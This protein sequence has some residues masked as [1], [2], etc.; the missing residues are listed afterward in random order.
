MGHIN[1]YRDRQYF[2]HELSGNEVSEGIR[3]IGNNISNQIN[4]ANSI[5][6][7]ANESTLANNQID[8]STK[9]LAKNNEINTKWQA[10]PTNPQR[11]K[12]I[13]EAFETLSS[14]YKV[15]PLCE[16]QWS[17]IKSNVFN[18]YKTYNAQWAEKQ[19]QTNI[20]TNL[21]NGYE[22]LTNQ[23]SMLGLNG[24]GVDEVRLIY[25]NGIEGLKN[26][27]IAGLGEVYVNEFLKDSNHDI[28][29]TYIS[30]LALNKP[31]E[32]QK[33]LNDEG[34][35]NDI[36]NAETLE[37]LDNYVSNSLNNQSKKTA[38]CELG[39]ALRSMNSKD[40]D[41]IING[42][43]DLNKVMKFVETNKNLPEGSKDL[44]LNIYGI[45]SKSEYFYDKDK[46]KIVKQEE[47][48][49]R[50]HSGRSGNSLVAL[51][52][53]SKMEKQDLAIKLEEGL[54]ELFSFGEIKPV[55][56]KNEI[57]NNTGKNTQNNVLARLQSVAEAQGAIDTAYNA[58]IITKAQRQNM[59]NKFI[60]PM[61][62]FLD[63]NMQNL[64]EKQ[65][66]F[67]AKLG[68]DRL[69]K[70]FSVDD[71][72]ERNKN[73]IRAVKKSLL[74]A[75]GSYY[76]S[77]EAAR[78]KY[79]LQSIYDLETLPAEQQ[80]QI[81]KKASD[82]AILYAKKYGE[83]P[84]VFFKQEYPQ[85][86]AQGVALF[87][88]K[89]GNKVA[90][91]VANAIYN[92]PENEKPDVKNEMAKAIKDEWAFKRNKAL[93]DSIRVYEK[94][95]VTPKPTYVKTELGYVK[96]KN[97]DSQMKLYNEQMQKRMKDLKISKSD[98]TETA[99]KYRITESQVLSM[100]EMQKYKQ[101]TGKDFSL[102][103]YQ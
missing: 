89:D 72:P 37:K 88:I 98:L 61:T 63:A 71:I 51:S 59:M 54:Y 86:Y 43:A 97:Y 18:R 20:Q 22:N 84:E 45:G 60:E 101:K 53:L 57:K 21:K 50:G 58:G 74:T 82:D 7:K 11:E 14:E 12:E 78:Q 68:Y 81:Y 79:G 24:A 10:D 32:A 94:H 27:A 8:L 41:D 46:Q 62:N 35:R 91:Q 102:S 29:T 48:I 55:N 69:K 33:L 4:T 103:D 73:E 70:Y 44:V 93:Q 13:Q 100:L 90:K 49:G 34:V 39:N 99:K 96:P 75:Q 47:K 92:A 67:G 95:F 17:D 28:M 6:Q 65:G 19:Q 64:D 1:T 56:A 52:K 23:I 66:W 25:A 15:N 38:V 42:K 3:R 31:L 2:A 30:A 85:L 26:G 36:G 83:H 80:R 77:L 40:A 87:G 76:S 9:F 5:I 16:K